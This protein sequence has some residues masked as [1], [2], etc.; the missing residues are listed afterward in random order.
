[1]DQKRYSQEPYKAHT[2]FTTGL[3]REEENEYEV[4]LDITLQSLFTLEMDVNCVYSGTAT[5]EPRY[6]RV[7]TLETFFELEDKGVIN[8]M[9]LIKGCHLNFCLN[10]RGFSGKLESKIKGFSGFFNFKTL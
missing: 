2:S 5:I 4:Y 6:E 3:S 7:N 10:F 8:A 1:M 9:P